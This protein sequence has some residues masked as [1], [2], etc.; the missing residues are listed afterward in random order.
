M[1]SSYGCNTHLLSTLA[2]L[3]VADDQWLMPCGNER[4]VRQNTEDIVEKQIN[5]NTLQIY[6]KRDDTF[7][8]M[9]KKKVQE[10]STK[11]RYRPRYKF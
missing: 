10:K 4:E 11:Q 2:G 3:P 8:V 9:I 7:F 1:S 6:N 5:L